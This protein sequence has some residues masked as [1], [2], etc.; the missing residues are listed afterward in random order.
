MI[1]NDPIVEEARSAGDA[2][3]KQFGH[4]L[5]AVFADLRRRTEEARLAGKRVVTLPARRVDTKAAT[6][7]A[8]KKAS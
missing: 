1:E 7:Q 6:I 8:A 3:M 5:K 2:Y 4:D